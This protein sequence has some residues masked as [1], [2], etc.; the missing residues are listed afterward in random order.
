MLELAA[1]NTR[2]PPDTVHPVVLIRHSETRQLR[3]LVARQAHRSHTHPPSDMSEFQPGLVTH[4]KRGGSYQ[5]NGLVWWVQGPGI[6]ELGVW[7]TGLY[8]PG[9]SGGPHWFRPLNTTDGKGWLDRP[10][11]NLSARFIRI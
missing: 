9:N 11:D 2:Q 10:T 3:Q 7:Y 4:Y 6:G 1:L 5:V 8:D